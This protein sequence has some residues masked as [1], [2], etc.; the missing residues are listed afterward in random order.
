[1]NLGGKSTAADGELFPKK[2]AMMSTVFDRLNTELE[3]VGERLR[4]VLSEGRRQAER[5]ALLAARSRVAT[6]L[7]HLAYAKERG[8]DFSESE[9][10]DTLARIDQLNAQIEAL[11]SSQ[12]DVQ[13]QDSSAAVADEAPAANSTAT[14]ENGDKSTDREYPQTSS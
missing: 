7:G 14:P 2:G 3:Q 12:P 13:P 4:S 5:G 9:M 6:R 1:M 11:G 8:R 10:Q